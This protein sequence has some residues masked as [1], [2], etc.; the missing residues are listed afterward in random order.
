MSQLLQTN[1]RLVYIK[2]T[3]PQADVEG[4]TCIADLHG[5]SADPRTKWYDL[6]LVTDEYG[7][8]LT[9]GRRFLV[10][11]SRI[12]SLR[13]FRDLYPKWIHYLPG[14]DQ[15]TTDEDEIIADR[16]VNRNK[17]IKPL[18]STSRS[19]LGSGVYGLYFDERTSLPHQKE[20]PHYILDCPQAFIIQD[21]EHGESL[22]LASLLTNRHLDNLITIAQNN[23]S[24]EELPNMVDV[25]YNITTLWNIVLYR[26][27]TSLTEERLNKILVS[28][29]VDYFSP[30]SLTDTE[31]GDPLQ[32]LPIN[33]I[34]RTLGYEGLLAHDNY[35]NGWDR[36]CVYYGHFKIVKGSEAKY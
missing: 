1:Q 15:V 28:Y 13:P 4:Y 2:N 22:T 12:I 32:E 34:L 20:G 14:V 21:K 10:D 30:T 29:L 5:V 23:Y 24:L 3:E 33:Y 19:A 16:Y 25:P 8:F 27:G 9:Q 26:I 7:N 6:S 11:E 31:T 36:G 18:E 35:N 17:T